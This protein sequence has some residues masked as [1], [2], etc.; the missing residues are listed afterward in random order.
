MEDWRASASASMTDLKPNMAQRRMVFLYDD[1]LS[2]ANIYKSFLPILSYPKKNY[3]IEFKCEIF[4]FC[5]LSIFK[6]KL[7][8]FLP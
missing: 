5:H 1:S 3:F 7:P 2:P 8:S 6:L 4:F